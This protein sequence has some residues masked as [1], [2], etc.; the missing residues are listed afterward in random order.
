MELKNDTRLYVNKAT[1]TNEKLE[2]KQVLISYFGFNG[3]DFGL[4]QSGGRSF[5]SEFICIELSTGFAVA[6][7]TNGKG[8]AREKKIIELKELVKKIPH[9]KMKQGIEK[10]KQVLKQNGIIHPVN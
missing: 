10:A 4:Y 8:G 2:L 6:T 3:F 7:L 9:E 1:G 5:E